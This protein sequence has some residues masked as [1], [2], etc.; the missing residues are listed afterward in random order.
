MVKPFNVADLTDQQVIERTLD[1]EAGDQGFAGQQGVGSVIQN[2][3]LLQWQ[4]ETTARGVCLH[5]AQFDCWLPGKDYDRITAEGYTPPESCTNIAQR[6]LRGD[7][8]DNTYAADS[9]EVTGSGAY[10]ASGLK[11]TKVIA[12]QSFYITRKTDDA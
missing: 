1:G 2:R 6:I 9:Y 4:G 5:H 10:W 12:D 3:S 11:P 8:P 7:L